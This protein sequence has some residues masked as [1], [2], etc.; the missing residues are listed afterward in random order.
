MDAALDRSVDRD[1][2]YVSVRTAAAVTYIRLVGASPDVRDTLR[3]Q[4]TL[5]QLARA[6]AS[7]APIHSYD[8]VSA[9][10]ARIDGAALHAARFHRGAAT[11]VMADG[12]EQKNLMVQRTDLEAAIAML[13]Q[14]SLPG[15]LK[16]AH[17]RPT[18]E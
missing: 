17:S 13:Q 18:G 3:M 8:A 1:L 11:L 16:A 9:T 6:L 5:N 14:T 4:R 2:Q 15:A 10:M 7:L 12:T